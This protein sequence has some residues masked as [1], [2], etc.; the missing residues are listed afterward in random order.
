MKIAVTSDNHTNQMSPH[1]QAN[2][3]AMIQNTIEPFN[4]IDVFC[5]AGD[6]GEGTLMPPN[7]DFMERLLGSHPKTLFVMG[8]HDLFSKASKKLTPDLA[9][10]K[11]LKLL[12]HGTPLEVSWKDDS[13][14]VDI[15]DCS[16]IGTIGFPDF[17]H[18]M[19][20]M[21]RKCYENDCNHRTI[22]STYIS[23][24]KW[25]DWTDS[26]NTAF[27]KRLDKAVAGNQKNVI[28]IS[29]YPCF[30]SHSR[31]DHTDP[32]WPYFYNHQLG[33]MILEAAQAN[34]T[35]KFWSIAGHSHE[36]C[37]G[38]WKMEWDNLYTLGIRTT[39]AQNAC[40]VFDT[41]KDPLI[42]RGTTNIP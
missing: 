19:L 6:L 12:K 36:Y 20:P 38:L 29:H 18:P 4:E 5:V 21:P 26:L 24:K 7:Q 41:E 39:Y 27:K 35:K 9:M 33:V 40:Y 11:N 31:G 15:G 8:N 17:K 3:N 1:A 25:C 30:L 16:F 23:L 10:E 32:V 28:I 42:D 34:P 22:D 37:L 13:T 14:V 2:F